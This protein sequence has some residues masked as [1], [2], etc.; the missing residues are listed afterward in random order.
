MEIDHHVGKFTGKHSS[1]KE[2]AGRRAKR[3]K[4]NVRSLALD[5]L[6]AGDA[7]S[8]EQYD[9]W[10]PAFVVT[11]LD[12]RTGNIR[13]RFVGA[14]IIWSN[15]RMLTQYSE[16]TATSVRRP[17]DVGVRFQPA[18]P[19]ATYG[20]VGYDNVGYECKQLM[21]VYQQSESP[22]A[23]TMTWRDVHP[24]RRNW[25]IGRAAAI[26][27]VARAQVQLAAACADDD[28]DAPAFPIDVAGLVAE[29]MFAKPPTE[30]IREECVVSHTWEVLDDYTSPPP[31]PPPP[32]TPPMA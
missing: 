15:G 28:D 29:F 8:V 32:Q 22:W 7:V 21:Q 5:G 24:A 18:A 16:T 31:L 6:K 27:F 17:Y 11:P 25:F 26:F 3:P 1:E 12:E 4:Y 14:D 10:A 2:N 20:A 13:V 9:E 23:D 19:M 30:I